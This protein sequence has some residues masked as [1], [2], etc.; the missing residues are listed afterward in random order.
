MSYAN[1]SV[2]GANF[3][4]NGLPSSQTLRTRSAYSLVQDGTDK[5]TLNF[6][7]HAPAHK[8]TSIRIARGAT[9]QML[10]I[11]SGERLDPTLHQREH[12]YS[13]EIKHEA[14]GKVSVICGDTPFICSIAFER[15]GDR[16]SLA[17]NKR[18]NLL[19]ME[20]TGGVWV[21]KFV[22]RNYRL[23]ICP[24]DTLVVTHKAG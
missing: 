18:K 2:F 6:E 13:V 16:Y 21:L 14:N 24:G 11:A 20:R 12:T 17:P 23:E 8:E 9:R 7:A 15:T 22:G 10:F 4:S 5:P 3:T 19:A 1:S